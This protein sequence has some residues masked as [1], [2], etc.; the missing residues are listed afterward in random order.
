M[1]LKVPRNMTWKE[2]LS[3]AQGDPEQSLRILRLGGNRSNELITKLLVKRLNLTELG[4]E[5][6][7]LHGSYVVG[8]KD[9]YNQAF[10]ATGPFYSWVSPGAKTYGVDVLQ[11]AVNRVM[12]H[13]ARRPPYGWHLRIQYGWSCRPYGA[14]PAAGVQQNQFQVDSEDSRRQRRQAALLLSDARLDVLH[15]GL[16]TGTLPRCPS[17][18]GTGREQREVHE[19]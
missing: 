8:G 16:R 11:P 19:D 17:S 7:Y 6:H 15:L 3:A 12:K 13:L 1:W 9:D 5:L 18:Q 4:F 10:A 14:E 2:V